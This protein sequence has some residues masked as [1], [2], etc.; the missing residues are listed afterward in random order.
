MDN[1]WSVRE[2]GIKKTKVSGENDAANRTVFQVR[3]GYQQTDPK[4]Q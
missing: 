4:M 3:V 1:A 2:E